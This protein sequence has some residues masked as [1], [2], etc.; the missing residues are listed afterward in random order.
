MGSRVAQGFKES[1]WT[2]LASK[3]VQQVIKRAIRFLARR[4]AAE[5]AQSGWLEMLS[6]QWRAMQ[7]L[8]IGFMW[9]CVVLFLLEGA[10]SLLSLYVSRPRLTV[11][12]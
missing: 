6:L 2:L 1:M 3:G 9:L 10:L 5:H 12:P 4:T 8:A 7:F 11:H